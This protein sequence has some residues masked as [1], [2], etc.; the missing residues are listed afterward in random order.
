MSDIERPD[1]W[2]YTVAMH[3]ARD[4]QRRS[5]RDPGPT[6]S[7][8]L[9]S[10]ESDVDDRIGQLWIVPTD[11]G[12]P[13]TLTAQTPK[14]PDLGDE[15]ARQLTTGTYLQ[16]A[17]ACGYQYLASLNPDGTTTPVSIPQVDTADN[18]QWVVGTDGTRIAVRMAAACGSGQSLLWWD[19][20][21]NTTTILLGPGVNG[22][23]VVDALF[24]LPDIGAD[25]PR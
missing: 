2:L 9:E 20:A 3:E 7:A 6:P 14:P 23:G 13:T 12:T 5:R 10:F 19:T 11:G 25:I 1:G 8:L 21:S 24:Y 18:S 22:G 16:D 4:H 15:N 17:G